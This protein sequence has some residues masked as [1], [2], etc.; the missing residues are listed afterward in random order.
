MALLSW[1]ELDVEEEWLI[2]LLSS[3]PSPSDEAL[4]LSC[5][6]PQSPTRGKSITKSSTDSVQTTSAKS[7]QSAGS[8]QV[9]HNH[10]SVASTETLLPCNSIPTSSTAY[11]DSPEQSSPVNIGDGLEQHPVARR[12]RSRSHSDSGYHEMRQCG[13]NQTLQGSS[14]TGMIM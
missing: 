2:K 11:T 13:S 14:L 10:T 5:T 1:E 8:D 9:T 4:V 12:R 3:T 6:A 7:S